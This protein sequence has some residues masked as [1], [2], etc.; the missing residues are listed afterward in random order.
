MTRTFVHV[1][2][3]SEQHLLLYIWHLGD[4]ADESLDR[5]LNGDAPLHERRDDYTLDM[6]TLNRAK[7]VQKERFGK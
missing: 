6:R 2:R 4:C 1:K 5:L 7:R 3:M